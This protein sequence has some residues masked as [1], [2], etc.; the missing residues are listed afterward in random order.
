MNS[1]HV[2]SY[3]SS[4]HSSTRGLLN[5]SLLLCTNYNSHLPTGVL[6]GAYDFFV[7]SFVGVVKIVR[8]VCAYSGTH[9]CGWDVFLLL[10]SVFPPKGGRG[11]S[12]PFFT[13]FAQHRIVV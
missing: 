10:I 9:I 1:G 8:Y 11:L 13:V 6:S 3:W 2:P 12:T 7:G 4:V 5:P